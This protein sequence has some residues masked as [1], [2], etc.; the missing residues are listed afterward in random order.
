MKRALLVVALAFAAVGCTRPTT[1]F[2]SQACAED[3]DCELMVPCCA[4]CQ[5][6]PMTRVDAQT[7]RDRCTTVECR[8]ECGERECVE[9]NK[10]AAC[11]NG[12]CTAV[13]R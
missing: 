7:E 8:N 9:S 3:T 10:R 1:Q 11:V 4:C 5:E 12:S 13:P 2:N 6:V